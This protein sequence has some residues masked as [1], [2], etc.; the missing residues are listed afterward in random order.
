MSC[1]LLTDCEKIIDDSNFRAD[2]LPDEY[3]IRVNAGELLREL[4]A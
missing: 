1:H 4:H 2:L 3:E